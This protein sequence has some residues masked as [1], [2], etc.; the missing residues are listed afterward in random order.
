[1]TGKPHVLL[2]GSENS[3]GSENLVGSGRKV[4]LVCGAGSGREL[5][6]QLLVAGYEVTAGVLG[7]GDS[8][9]EA[10]VRLGV[11]Y[12]DAPP[13]SSIT[14]EQHEQHLRLIGAADHVVVCAMAVGMNNLRNVD[15][16]V[17][18][19]SVY[20]IAPPFVDGEVQPVGDYTGGV[21]TELRRGLVERFGE[22]AES[23][24]LFELARV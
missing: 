14:D 22:V 21:S 9:R 16:V 18:A 1:M 20:L 13:F 2:L 5:M 6:H 15:A 10:A 4:H 24:L 8:D 19:E 17:G 23:S 7:V 12:V 3:A 11:E